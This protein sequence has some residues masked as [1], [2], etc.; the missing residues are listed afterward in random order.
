MVEKPTIES[1]TK[2]AMRTVSEIGFQSSP[3][4]CLGPQ[5]FWIWIKTRSKYNIFLNNIFHKTVSNFISVFL[6]KIEK[7]NKIILGLKKNLK[8]L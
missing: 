6:E 5:I 3:A 7:F 4:F 2:A 8:E 1:K